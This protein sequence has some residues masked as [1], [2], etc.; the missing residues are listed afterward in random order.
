[1]IVITG[2]TQRPS[3]QF[4]NILWLYNLLKFQIEKL[5]GV[6][7]IF[8]GETKVLS[9]NEWMATDD[10]PELIGADLYI[11]FEL[12]NK[13]KKK[14][15]EV[16]A[17]YIDVMIHP[18]RFMDDLII[19]VRSNFTNF[20]SYKVSEDK[21]YF[22][23]AQVSAAV[24]H[25]TGV[26]CEE[27]TALVVGQTLGDKS[28]T[29][30]R[31]YNLDDFGPRLA[32]ELSEFDLVLYKPHPHGTSVPAFLKSL[33]HVDCVGTNTYKLLSI[34]NIKAVFGLSSSVL[35]EAKYFDKKSVN[36]LPV[37]WDNL[38]GVES[39]TFLSFDFWRYALKDFN[40]NNFDMEIYYQHSM[41][42]KSA[43]SY[44]GYDILDKL[45]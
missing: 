29:F 38:I 41:L 34:P 36:M 22:T 39:K 31:E 12:N 24:S 21:L 40:P 15:S 35:C 44:W 32:D 5:T 7:P 13:F 45:P 4:H 16:G 33:D 9:F 3:P 28:V 23:A 14:A 11:G 2:D 25:V 19:G 6:K 27:N 1:M 42:R 18:V 37:W 26:R 17:K 10:T 8:L 43:R 20:S 30:D